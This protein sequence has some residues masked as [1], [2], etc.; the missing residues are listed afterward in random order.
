MDVTK[1]PKLLY[2]VMPSNSALKALILF[3]VEI[4]HLSLAYHIDI[5]EPSIF[6]VATAVSQ[7]IGEA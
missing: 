3:I 7:S 4:C 1:S 6:S 5:I 2:G